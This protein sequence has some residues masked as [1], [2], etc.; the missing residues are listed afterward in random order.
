MAETSSYTPPEHVIKPAE[1][2]NGYKIVRKAYR[3]FIWT[4]Q[5][6]INKH[7]LK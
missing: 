7:P 1:N 4:W 2:D 5:D 6:Y 3:R